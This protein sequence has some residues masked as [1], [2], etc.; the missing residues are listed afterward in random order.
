MLTGELAQR[1]TVDG[2]ASAIAEAVILRGDPEAA[3]RRL[4]Q[5]AA[6]TPADIQRVAR[7]WLRDE[8]SAALRYLPEELRGTAHGDTVATAA[9]VAAAPLV[10]PANIPIIQPASEAER[11]APPAPGPDVIPAVPAPVIQHLANGFTLITVP[12]HSRASGQRHAG[13]ARRL[14]RRS[15]GPRRPG[16]A[17]P[18]R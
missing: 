15:G 5:I 1:E 4:A 8:R 11:V 17:W 9:T 2:Q 6:V 18:R 3:N 10:P 14:G 12:S 16:F 13:R 7:L